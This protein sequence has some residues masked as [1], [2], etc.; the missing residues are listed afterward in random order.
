M[1]DQHTRTYQNIQQKL[2]VHTNKK[3][4][5]NILLLLN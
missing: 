3:A 5:N 4:L 1:V 2:Q